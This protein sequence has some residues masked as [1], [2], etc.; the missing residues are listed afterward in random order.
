MQKNCGKMFYIVKGGRIVAKYRLFSDATL[1]LP[2]SICK[3][4][5]VEIIPMDFTMDG[6]NY[7]HYCDEREMPVNTFYEKLRNGSTTTTSQINYETFFNTFEKVLK[8]GEDILYICFTSGMS[9][10][11]NTCNIAVADLKEKYPD[12]KILVADSLCA[13]IGEGLLVYNA[14]IKYNEGV[15]ID[16]LYNWITENRTKVCHWFIVDDLEQL[17]R[18]G[19]ISG[20]TAAIGK[21]LQIKPL[22]SV[23]MDG[24]L[25]NISKIRGNKKVYEA[26]IDK[27]KRDGIDTRKQTVIIG[28]GDCP[29]KAEELA[30][31]LKEENLVSDIIVSSIGPVIGTHTGTGMLA[32]TFMGKRNL[33]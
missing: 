17:K 28:N 15:Q 16:E 4:L 7:K 27:L 9:G 23:D 12:R 32:L 26:L 5:N 20:A 6:V 10:T 1:D 21:A 31:L 22:I 14:G 29:E 3:K 18:G 33:T 13:S 24:K 2:D 30:E 8:N 11:F 25:I 19:R